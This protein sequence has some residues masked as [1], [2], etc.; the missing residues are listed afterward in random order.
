MKKLRVDIPDVVFNK[1]EKQK[2]EDKFGRKP[3]ADWF[4][5]I[6][7]NVTLVEGFNEA[8]TKGTRDALAKLWM[9]NFVMNLKFIVDLDTYPD[10][11]DANSLGLLPK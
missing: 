3:W 9:E 11:K 4:R 5:H 10:G 8:I 7:K 1:L 2:R 6:T